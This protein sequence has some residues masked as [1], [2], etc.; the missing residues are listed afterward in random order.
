[1]LTAA[2]EV[3]AVNE[4]IVAYCGRTLAELRHW[5]TGDTIHPDDLPRANH[6]IADATISGQAYEF[7]QRMRRF[8]GVYRW[9]QLRGL[10]LREPGGRTVRWY[11][12]FTDIDDLKRAEAELRALKDQLYEENL[13][14][15]DEV[16]RTSMF[17]EIVGTS[18]A[19]Q[20]VLARVSK[21]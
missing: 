13:V 1:T 19:L 7:A 9:F 3:E 11:V 18:P 4:Q 8:D 20:P 21:V 2:G 10:P 6:A 15:R 16:D 14:L 17:E 12:L 5:G